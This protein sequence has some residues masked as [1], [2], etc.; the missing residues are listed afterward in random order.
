VRGP[1]RA[2]DLAEHPDR[3]E[4]FYPSLREGLRER[5]AGDV[6]HHQEGAAV[7]GAPIVGAGDGGMAQAAGGA[8]FPAQRV[9]RLRMRR[10]FGMEDFQRDRVVERMHDLTRR[11]AAPRTDSLRLAGAAGGAED[12]L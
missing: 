6:F 2:R 11:I 5:L 3:R 7:A 10:E 9:H 12:L 8:D 1:E 4:R